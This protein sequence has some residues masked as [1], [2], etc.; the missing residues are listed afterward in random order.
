MSDAGFGQGFHRE[1]EAILAIWDRGGFHPVEF[2]ANL[3]KAGVILVDKID[4]P[5]IDPPEPTRF[6]EE[7]EYDDTREVA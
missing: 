1:V 7:E 6:T 2:R 5:D 4:T 3:A